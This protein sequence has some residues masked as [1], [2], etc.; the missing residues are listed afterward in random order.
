MPDFEPAHHRIGVRPR[1]IGKDQLAP[2][3]LADRGAELRI[4][5]QRRVIDLMDH[6]EK[7]VRLKPVLLH[8]AAHRRAVAPVIILLQAERLVMADLQEIGDVVANALVDLVPQV[9]MM[10]IKRVVEIEHPG[11][12]SAEPA[13]RVRSG[14]LR[15][16]IAIFHRHSV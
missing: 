5:R 1:A 6:F 9:E 10:R 16:V 15:L 3:Q 13:R 14:S 12:D 11:R 2:G 4:W 8:Q 7:F